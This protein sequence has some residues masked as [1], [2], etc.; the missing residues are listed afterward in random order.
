[1]IL[2]RVVGTVVATRKDPRLEGKKLLILKPISP[3]GKDEAGYVVAV[4]TVSDEQDLVVKE[5]RGRRRDFPFFS[6]ATILA[7]G[8]IVPIVDVDA[9]PIDRARVG[10]PDQQSAP[11]AGGITLLFV[12]ERLLIGPPPQTGEPAPH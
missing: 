3:D 4:D 12:A 1:M 11:V 8:D 10:R 2:A 7:N 9:V 6:A 5:I